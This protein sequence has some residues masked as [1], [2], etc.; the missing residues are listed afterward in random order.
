[1]PL[2]DTETT[3]AEEITVPDEDVFDHIPE[4]NAFRPVLKELRDDGKDWGEIFDELHDAFNP[5]DH[6]A[7]DE[8]F[9][10]VPEYEIRAVVPDSKATS[11]E[12]YETFTRCGATEEKA[13]EQIRSKPEVRRIES[14]ER[15]GMVKVG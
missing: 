12:R 7:C 5:V 8:S 13:L 11:G 3:D 14:S 15:L 9:V 1:M 10:K 6:A 2:P 4:D